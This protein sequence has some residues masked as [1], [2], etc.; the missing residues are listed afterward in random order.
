[1]KYIQAL[2][3]LATSVTTANTWAITPTYDGTDGIKAMIFAKNCLACHSSQLTGSNR[4]GAP[5]PVN[6]D[7]YE[8]AISK[9]TRAVIRAVQLGNM[10]P[11]FSPLSTLTDGQKQALK[12]WQ[13]LNFPKTDLPTIFTANTAELR[14]PIV[15][16]K[17]T[18]GNISKQGSANFKLLNN[19][20]G[21]IQFGLTDFTEIK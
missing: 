9:G 3:L 16:I 19:N 21:A 2:T 12:N 18:T 17:D 5:T 1:M 14:I 10:P 8:S 13:V 7:T 20:T 15:Y 6:F 11:A 4:N